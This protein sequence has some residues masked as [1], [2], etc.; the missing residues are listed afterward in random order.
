MEMGPYLISSKSTSVSRSSAESEAG[1]E[2]K[3]RERKTGSTQS[4]AGG[5]C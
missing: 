3:K 2:S 4:S 1:K 5:H